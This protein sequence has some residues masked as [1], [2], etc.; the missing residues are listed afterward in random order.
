MNFEHIIAINDLNNPLL[1]ALNRQQLWAGLMFRVNNPVPF[2]P[3]LEACRILER[4]A[5]VIIR[6][7]DFG[8]VQMRD[9]VTLQTEE[10]VRFD[11]EPGKSHP[12]GSLTIRIEEP[13]RGQFFLRFKYESPFAE[14]ASAE[15]R[16]YS[17]YLKSAY[18]Q[19]DIDCV[20]IIRTLAV[21]GQPQ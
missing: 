6:S 3:G 14:T 20:D 9:R 5:E 2:L 21:E 13:Q 8:T 17:E 12:G 16:A 4:R 15:D 19:S 7:L 11:I 10:W 18:Q 1:P